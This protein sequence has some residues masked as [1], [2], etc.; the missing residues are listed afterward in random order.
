MTLKSPPGARHKV[1]AEEK[2]SKLAFME[3]HTGAKFEKFLHFVIELR[4][5]ERTGLNSKVQP[6][7]AGGPTSRKLLSGPLICSSNLRN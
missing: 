6:S 7:F 1:I 5:V 4:R 2:S 3:T